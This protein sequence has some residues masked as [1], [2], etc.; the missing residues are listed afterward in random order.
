MNVPGWV[1][2]IVGT[3]AGPPAPDAPLYVIGDIHGC[4]DLLERLVARFDPALPVVCLGDYVDRGPDSA[5]VLRWLMARPEITCLKGNHEAMLLEFLKDPTRRGRRWLRFGG[6]ETLASFGLTGAPDPS[7]AT[8][9]RDLRDGLAEAMGA[10]A[11]A[12][13][14]ALP[15]RH[16]TGNVAV[17]H[18]GADPACP[19][20]DQPDGTL[21]W[22][23][24][25]FG[26]KRRS[27]GIWVVYGHVIHPEPRMARGCIALDTGA[28]ATGRLSAARLD[29]SG[30]VTFLST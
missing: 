4:P 14:E 18:A 21:I 23:H 22:G 17:V 7:D 9:L 12:W 3:R 27:D 8:A 19:V 29:P 11:L 15:A 10:G 24:P 6:L 1:R 13:L 25:D 16:L 5:A 20:A 30:K 28:Y 26:R 2:R